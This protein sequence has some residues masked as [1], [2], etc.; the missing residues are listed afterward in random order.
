MIS[1]I[2]P[3][4]NEERLL[5]ATLEALHVTGQARGEP[6]EIIVADDASTDKTADVARDHGARV[7]TIARRQIAAARNAGAREAR[8]DLFIFVD[9][10]TLVNEAVVGAAVQAVRDGAIGGGSAVQFDGFVPM[11]AKLL[12]PL[13]TRIFRFARLAAGCF[14]FCTRSAF[15]AVGGF[16]EA[17][18]GAEEL[19]I[20]RALGREGRFVVLPQVV[21]TSGRKLRTYSGWEVLLL[22]ARFALLGPSAV[23]RREGMDMWYAE[24]REEPPR[25][26]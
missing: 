11:Y 19:V 2:V 17:Y 3:A 24:R 9:A 6:Y 15:V 20:S 25:N 10:D 5:G 23:K 8:G 22:I 16:D 12:L 7:V 13:F 18:F 26:A 4:Y 14:V 1:F 21:T